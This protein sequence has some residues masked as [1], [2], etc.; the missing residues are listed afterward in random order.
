MNARRHAAFGLLVFVPAITR[1]QAAP[2]Q[3]ADTASLIALQRA[4]RQQDPRLRQLNLLDAQSKLRLENIT[5]D[6]KPSFVLESQSQYQSDVATIP[7]TLPTG[8]T[9][10]TPP[11]DTYDAHL[12]TRYRLY[13]ASVAPR[14]AVEEAQ[15]AESRARVNTSLY[16]LR[17]S[18]NDAYF[19]V[20]RADAQRADLET[21]ITDLEAQITLAATRVREGAA[22]RSEETILRA[23]LLRRRQSIASLVA[24][25][26]AA[27]D[28]LADLTGDRSVRTD[29][30]V[31]PDSDLSAERARTL[32]SNTR[33]RPEFDQFARTREV[34][35]KQR[36]ART[37]QDKPRVAA[38]G[39]LGFGRPGLN[40]LA[41]TFDTYWLAG[42]QLE[43]TPFNWGNT[44]R[45]R[46]VL[47]LQR[48]IVAAD[49]QAFAESIRRATRD[50][51]ETIARLERELTTDDEIIALRESVF[52][53]ARARFSEGV[54]TSSELVDRQTDVL[55][56]RLTRSIHRVELAQ[57][58]TRFLTTLGLETR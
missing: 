19:A 28:V 4:A 49:E 15:L 57:A 41:N 43:W 24:S 9:I 26:A 14:R 44:N 18:V 17:Q 33:S 29:T 42:V 10:P 22:L 36:D 45:E 55:S 35:D 52:A 23:E 51:I 56:A 54:I 38:Y 21:S 46:E 25:R 47:E 20:L 37:A 48:Q 39:R 30:F 12:N 7:V 31:I 40:P 1:A 2:R 53:E 27:I 16:G 8:G 13:D 6:R 58:R 5:T 34:L 3:S 11:H 32:A 50:D